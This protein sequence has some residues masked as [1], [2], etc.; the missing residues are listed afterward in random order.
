MKL[1]YVAARFTAHTDW[2]R[3]ELVQLARRHG[4]EIAKAGALP[5]MP[6]A[7]SSLFWEQCTE[8][9]WR[10]GYI[11]L[12]RRCDAIYLC[13]GWEASKG[14]CAEHEM[15]M[16]LRMPVFYHGANV[17]GAIAAWVAEAA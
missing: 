1:V 2:E 12:L 17:I 15:A 4:L 11:E 9:F 10:A 6:T 16:H 8:V 7:N 14:C 5:I 3:S 13:P